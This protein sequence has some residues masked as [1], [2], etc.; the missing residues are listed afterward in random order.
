MSEWVYLPAPLDVVALLE[1]RA[2][3]EGIEDYDRVLYA[4]A[5][6]TLE[7]ALDRC[8]QLASTIEKTE[9]GL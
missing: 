9:A 3:A 1:R 6:K 7:R 2:T 5:A 8:C 4:A